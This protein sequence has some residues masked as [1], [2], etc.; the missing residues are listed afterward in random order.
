MSAVPRYRNAAPQKMTTM[1]AAKRVRQACGSKGYAP[2]V[3]MDRLV[4]MGYLAVPTPGANSR[5]RGGPG[6]TLGVRRGA[7]ASGI[8]AKRRFCTFSTGATAI[9]GERTPLPDARRA[10]ESPEGG[11]CSESGRKWAGLGVSGRLRSRKVP[12]W[13]AWCVGMGE[14]RTGCGGAVWKT[15]GNPPEARGGLAGGWLV[16]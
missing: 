14:K 3:S 9:S 2:R 7:G 15:C 12:F 16:G 13:R 11:V 5:P 8:E 1:I 10:L 4:S 6:P